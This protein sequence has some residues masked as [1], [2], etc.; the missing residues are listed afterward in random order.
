MQRSDF[1]PRLNPLLGNLIERRRKLVDEMT[2]R[3]GGDA[4]TLSALMV[5]LG[6]LQGCICAVTEVVAE[7]Q[8][9]AKLQR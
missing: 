8:A 9:K 5:Q 1:D 4:E 6:I 2:R 3:L 7:A